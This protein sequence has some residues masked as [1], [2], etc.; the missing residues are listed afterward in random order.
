MA[1]ETLQ[2]QNKAEKRDR[3]IRNLVKVLCVIIAFGLWIYVMMVE[4]PSYEETFYNVMVDLTNTDSLKQN[5][6][7][8]YSGYGN[9]VDVTLSG[10]K[11]VL[12]QLT[13]A[14]L[15]V[16]AD[17]SSVAGESGRYNVKVNVDVP[18]GCKLVGTSSETV[19]VYLDQSSEK[20]MDITERRINTNL[21]EGSAVGTIELPVDKV[22]V[23]GPSILLARVTKAVLDID[24]AGIT[25]TTTYTAKITLYDESDTKVENPYLDYY[26]KE[27]SFTIPVSKTVSVDLGVYFKYGFLNEENTEVT[28]VPASVS[29]TG[30]AD[31][32]NRGGLVDLI[33]IDEKT[34]FNGSKCNMMV[35]LKSVDGVT[36]ST[37]FAEVTAVMGDSIRTRK[38]TISGD[39]ISVKG[40]NEGV[41]YEFDKVS[42]EVTLIGTMEALSAVSADD[43]IIELDLSPYFGPTTGT[44]L[45]KGT[46]KVNTEYGDQLLDVGS[47]EIPVTFVE[48]DE[49]TDNQD[50]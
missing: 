12:S 18:S 21:P 41:H 3:L 44:Y 30:D 38:V 6:L 7:A 48:H 43:V 35:A 32:I 39:N 34:D 29:V 22:T 1:E 37:G 26:P 17:I 28:I 15:V 45:V 11:S 10:K 46:V 50:Q 25:K 8:V 40:L 5:N 13:A 36:L 14:N 42:T 16:T 20:V 33:E 31:L 24:M 23:T 27:V 9:L 47:Y 4:S 49:D 19:S 2:N